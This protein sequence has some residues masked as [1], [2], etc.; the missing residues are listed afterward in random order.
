MHSQLDIEA[1]EL[2]RNIALRIEGEL[3]Y[4][5]EIKVIVIRESRVIEY[6]R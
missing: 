6:A 1:K 5:G 3:K 4:P 2:A